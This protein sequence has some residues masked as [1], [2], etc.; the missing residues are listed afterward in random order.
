MLR[1]QRRMCPVDQAFDLFYH[2]F[3]QA[4]IKALVDLGVTDFSR[5]QCTYI[6]CVL[7]E[8]ACALYGMFGFIYGYLQGTDQAFAGVIV[9]AVMER[10]ER[11]Q[12]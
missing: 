10:L 3:F 6:I 12:L 2:T 8:K 5:Y 7:R 1:C 4:C 11:R 9:S